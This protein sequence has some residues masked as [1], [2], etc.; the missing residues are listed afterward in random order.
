MQTT[1]NLDAM[2]LFNTGEF[3]LNSGLSSDF[4][5][6]ADALTDEDIQALAHIIKDRIVPFGWVEGVPTGGLRLAAALSPFATPDDTDLGLIA[7]DV[8]T[9]G[10]SL[11]KQRAGRWA[12]G[13]VLFNRFPMGKDSPEWIES[14]WKF[15]L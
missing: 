2:N 6:D 15:G 3:R 12:M 1:W 11:E 10:N 8:M 7:D 4:K 13:I 9:T 14:V 5:I